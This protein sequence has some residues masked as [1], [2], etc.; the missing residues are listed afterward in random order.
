MPV[1]VSRVASASRAMPKSASLTAGS[2]RRRVVSSASALVSSMLAG[3]DVAMHDVALVHGRERRGHVPADPRGLLDVE[4]PVPEP[5]GQRRSLDQLHH[6]VDLFR[7]VVAGHGPR[8]R[9]A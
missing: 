1:I 8:R 3:L 5:L 9:G 7:A 6:E 4:R 2:P